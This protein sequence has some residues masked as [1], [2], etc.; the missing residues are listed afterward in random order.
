MWN[1]SFISFWSTRDFLCLFLKSGH[2]K[3]VNFFTGISFGFRNN[4][5]IRK[6]SQSHNFPDDIMRDLRTALQV[7]T[8]HSHP[9]QAT[10]THSHHFLTKTIH[11]HQFSRKWPTPS[12]LSRKTT[13]SHS[14]FVKNDPLPP[15]FQE[16][17][18][19]LTY[20]SRKTTRSHP[21]FNKNGTLLPL[22]WQ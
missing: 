14:F 9:L 21:F 22:F 2:N 6:Y 20:F 13:H 16:Q 7:T 5:V 3:N 19:T 1:T 11:S 8:S 12:H 4:T 15:I 18:P 17:W 10:L